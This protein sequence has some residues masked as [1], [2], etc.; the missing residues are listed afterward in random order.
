[1]NPTSY[2]YILYHSVWIPIKVLLENKG[3]KQAGSGVW[4][5]FLTLTTII[6]Y[7]LNFKALK[8]M[9]NMVGKKQ[10]FVYYQLFTTYV[11][12]YKICTKIIKMYYVHFIEIYCSFYPFRD[13]NWTNFANFSIIRGAKNLTS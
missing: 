12:Q 8:L 5:D 2:L 9:I 13:H 7:L 1:M 6:N 3:K 4:F 11:L 10:V